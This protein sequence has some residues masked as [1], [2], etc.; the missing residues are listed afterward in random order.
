ME[1]GQNT[2]NKIVE[3]QKKQREYSKTARKV[4]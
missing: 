3:R 1:T 4:L 2:E